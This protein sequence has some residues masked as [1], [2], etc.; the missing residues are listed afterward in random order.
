MFALTEDA[1]Q[2]ECACTRCVRRPLWNHGS[3]KRK[4]LTPS[5]PLFLLSFL[6]HS[7]LARLY[8]NFYKSLPPFPFLRSFWRSWRRYFFLLFSFRT[9]PFPVVIHHDAGLPWGWGRV[10][11]RVLQHWYCPTDFVQCLSPDMAD[12]SLVSGLILSEPMSL[13]PVKYKWNL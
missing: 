8:R 11:G 6:F 13:K 5:F 1:T 3:R 12:Q 9:S 2:S 7:L 10:R 4:P